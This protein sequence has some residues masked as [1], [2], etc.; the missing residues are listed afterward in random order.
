MHNNVFSRLKFL[1]GDLGL[2]I[3]EFAI[4]C[5]VPYRTMQDYFAGKIIPGGDKLTKIA[6]EFRVSIDWLLSGE[7]EMYREPTAREDRA[8]YNDV[9]DVTKLIIKLL[10]EMPEEDQRDILKRVEE[11][12][13]LRELMDERKDR[14]NID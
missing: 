1:I 4:K 14:K 13:L 12:K 5:N 10:Q 7:G 6:A 8:L 11:K 3:K 9:S 2:N